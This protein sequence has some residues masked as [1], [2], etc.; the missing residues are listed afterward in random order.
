MSVTQMARR[1]AVTVKTLRK[2]AGLSQNALAKKAKLTQA[3]ISMLETGAI[4]DP[5]VS[6]IKQLARALGVSPMRLLR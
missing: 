2:R 6:V 5:K 3:A 4:A 1:L